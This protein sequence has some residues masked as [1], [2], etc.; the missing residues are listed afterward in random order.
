M[1]PRAAP[2]ARLKVVSVAKPLSSL[3]RVNLR[4]LSPT[5]IQGLTTVKRVSANAFRGADLTGHG[6]RNKG[7]TGFQG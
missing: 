7:S 4:V 1:S 6:L 3:E 5:V 2:K